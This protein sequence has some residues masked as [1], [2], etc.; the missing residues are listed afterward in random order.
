[1]KV[2]L[3]K[4]RLM[5]AMLSGILLTATMSVPA[6]A[7]DIEDKSSNTDTTAETIWEVMAESEVEDKGLLISEIYRSVSEDALEISSDGKITVSPKVL[8]RVEREILEK[9]ERLNDKNNELVNKD[10][11]ESTTIKNISSEEFKNLSF[12]QKVE[13]V[14]KTSSPKSSKPAKMGSPPLMPPI[15]AIMPP[16]IP[17]TV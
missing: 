13:M 4:H 12:E 14:S 7:A 6:Y 16:S 8:K 10:Q 17:K 5:A 3:I 2:N 15:P 11:I 1:M 9:K